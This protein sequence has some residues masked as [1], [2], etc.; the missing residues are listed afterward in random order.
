M[1]T[2]R[3]NEFLTSQNNQTINFNKDI[4]VNDLEGNSRVI[5][6]CY[7]TIINGRSISYYMT[8]EDEEI[9]EN[10]K[11]AIQVEITKFKEEAVDLA[12]KN[13]VPII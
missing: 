12:T 7:C 6:K 9:F 8:V 13:N 1:R 3:I 10:N 2:T 4:V 11:E 5:V